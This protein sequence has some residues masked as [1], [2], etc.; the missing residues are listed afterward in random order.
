MTLKNVS[1]LPT[2]FSRFNSDDR[3]LSR[4]NLHS[5]S[6][7]SSDAA[8]IFLLSIR[9][10]IINPEFS[11]TIC[12]HTQQYKTGAVATGEILDV[13]ASLMAFKIPPDVGMTGIIRISNP[14]SAGPA[15]GLP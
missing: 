2:S 8:A 13:P 12:K 7:I 11:N 14:D 1:C 3:V 9:A 5:L 15:S 4:P 6:V 10:F